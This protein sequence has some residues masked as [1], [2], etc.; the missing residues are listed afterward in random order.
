M[1]RTKR[2]RDSGINNPGNSNIESPWGL[3]YSKRSNSCV[4]FIKRG[5]AVLL[6]SLGNT[7]EII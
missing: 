2:R 1:E 3:C 6:Y 7:G 5:I 4:Y